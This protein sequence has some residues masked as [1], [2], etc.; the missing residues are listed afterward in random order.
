MTRRDGDKSGLIRRKPDSRLSVYNVVGSVDLPVMGKSLLV[1]TVALMLGVA[2]LPTAA[3]SA[4]E[5]PAIDAQQATPGNASIAPGEA[6][7]GAVGVQRQELHGEV[8]TR[9]YG[10][11]IAATRSEDGKARV[12]ANRTRGVERRLERLRI[13]QEELRQARQNGSISPG[14]YRAEMA[15]VAAR[16]HTTEQ[17]LN[18][19][20]STARSLPE[21]VRNRHGLNIS[22][23][24]RLRTNARNMTGPE[25]AAIARSIAGPPFDGPGRRGPPDFVTDDG[26]VSDRGNGPGSNGGQGPPENTTD[27]DGGPPVNATDRGSGPPD[28]AG[29]RTGR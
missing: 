6:F 14:R 15:Q 29:N 8:E 24:E 3:I 23:I 9:A 1:I 16:I 17:L 21:P 4:E 20:E 27:R 12:V 5:G 22:A 28:E 25:V 7:A 19:S 10:L 11:S 18:Q 13:H 2:A 26:N